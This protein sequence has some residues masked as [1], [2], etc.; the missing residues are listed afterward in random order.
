MGKIELLNLTEKQVNFANSHG[1][2]TKEP[3]PWTKTDTDTSSGEAQRKQFFFKIPSS[4][5]TNKHT[6]EVKAL[7]YS[8]VSIPNIK[9]NVYYTSHL[10]WVR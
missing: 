3:Q 1:N 7:L 9:N 5:A 6:L 4:L 2:M 10:E 8:L